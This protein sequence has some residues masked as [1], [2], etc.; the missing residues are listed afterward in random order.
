[1]QMVM[2]L[3]WVLGFCARIQKDDLVGCRN[4]KRRGPAYEKNEGNKE[5]RGNRMTDREPRERK[6]K[7]E[8]EWRKKGEKWAK[9]GKNRIDNRHTERQRLTELVERSRGKVGASLVAPNNIFGNLSASKT[10]KT[11]LVCHFGDENIHRKRNKWIDLQSKWKRTMLLF[12]ATIFE[13]NF[14]YQLPH[15][16]LS[17]RYDLQS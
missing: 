12:V 6:D 13:N 14:L 4:E 11:A 7:W 1:M 9:E 10:R 16:S 2:I 17:L 3:V 5:G 15:S 8:Q